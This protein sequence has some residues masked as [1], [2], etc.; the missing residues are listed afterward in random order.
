MVY[1]AIITIGDEILYGQTLD[2]NAHFISGELDKI[3]IKV[4]LRLSVGDQSSDILQALD[5]ARNSCDIIL[6]TGGLGPTRDDITKRTL[7][8]YFGVEL[9]RNEDA[10]R[11]VENFFNKRGIVM[12]ELNQMQALLPTGSKKITNSMGTAPGI[13][14]EWNKKVYISMP[15]VPH[16]LEHMLPVMVIPM[17]RQNFVTPV[18]YHKSI[19]TA[20]IGESILAEKIKDWE[21][22]LPENIKLAYLPGYGLV[23]LRLSAFGNDRDVLQQQVS[24]YTGELQKIAGEHIYGY[25]ELS[26]EQKVGDLLREQ[27]ETLA[28]AESCT[29]GYL[30]HAITSVP[31]SSDYFTGGI[32]AYQNKL[33]VEE[34]KVSES[35]LRQEGAVS[36]KT[37][38]EM[39]EGIRKKFSAGWG[40]A[41]SGIA[42]PGGGT[43]DKPVGTVWIGLSGKEFTEARKYNFAKN[44]INNI[45][46][47]SVAALTFLWQRLKEKN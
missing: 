10:L 39:A 11:D 32:I 47:A 43:H 37:V 15:G 26:L 16:E 1:A 17:I 46:Y 5:T 23:K 3:G 19:M 29:G 8:A 14:M 44:R 42:G 6:T 27:K 18:I 4:K 13:W 35:T 25:D 20:G 40:V 21:T 36:E 41:I 7:C 22:G 24:Q 30:S 33:K 31:G 45:R 38:K 2:T 9:A 12:N 28:V 34:L